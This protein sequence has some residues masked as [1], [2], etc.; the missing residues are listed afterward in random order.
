SGQQYLSEGPQRPF[1][2]AESIDPHLGKIPGTAAYE[3]AQADLR[4]ATRIALSAGP[5]A[6][7][8]TA[9]LRK[10]VIQGRDL[11]TVLPL[12][13][14]RVGLYETGTGTRPTVGGPDW[15]DLDMTQRM[16]GNHVN[17][18]GLDDAWNRAVQ[19]VRSWSP[20]QAAAIDEY[21]KTHPNVGP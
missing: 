20:E 17:Q 16:S 18:A 8:E 19:T 15:T 5:G 2:V 14:R 4:R 7:G 9:G 3:Q 10:G 1:S 12:Q 6:V 11:D 21:L 13:N